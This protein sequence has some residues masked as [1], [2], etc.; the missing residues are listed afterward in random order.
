[1]GIGSELGA[2]YEHV[3]TVMHGKFNAGSRCDKGQENDPV[4]PLAA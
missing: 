3:A 2:V 4:P 1:M